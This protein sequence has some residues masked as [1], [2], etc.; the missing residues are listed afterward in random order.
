MFCA[1]NSGAKHALDKD[2]GSR[3]QIGC[4]RLVSNRRSCNNETSIAAC[5]GKNLRQTRTTVI[6][7]FI[8][9][10]WYFGQVFTSSQSKHLKSVPIEPI[11]HLMCFNM[12][13][14][15]SLWRNY[16]SQKTT[17]RCPLKH[18]RFATKDSLQCE[19]SRKACSVVIALHITS[20]MTY[21]DTS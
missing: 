5:D 19:T 1:C 20:Q 15:I 17:H 6:D 12:R 10:D 11:Q 16:F 2:L 3:A 21:E 4:L 14:G 7:C 8:Q 9:L 13:L 18:L